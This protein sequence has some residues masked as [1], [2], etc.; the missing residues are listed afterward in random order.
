MT[1]RKLDVWLAVV[2]AALALT[3]LALLAV[4]LLVWVFL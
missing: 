1:N 4:N 2:I 3:G